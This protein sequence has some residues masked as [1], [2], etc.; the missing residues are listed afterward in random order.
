MFPPATFTGTFALTAF[1]LLTASE[2]ADCDVS[3]SCTPAWKPPAPPQ[4]ALQD[5]PPTFWVWS[6]F[7]VVSASFDEFA[8]AS[9]LAAWLAELGPEVMFPPATFTGTFAL[10]AF[11][12]L[13]ASEP[14]DCDVSASCTPAWKPPAPPQPALQDEPPQLALQDEP[15]TFWVWSCFWVV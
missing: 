1:C 2:P 10:T 6:C 8:S 15:P 14:A 5:E 9:E 3:A 11:C 4:P 7:W 13:T 12:L